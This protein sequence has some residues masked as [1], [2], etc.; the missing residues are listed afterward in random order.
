MRRL[1]D[2]QMGV[3]DHGKDRRAKKACSDR[4]I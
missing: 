1:A 4:R 2:S 3:I